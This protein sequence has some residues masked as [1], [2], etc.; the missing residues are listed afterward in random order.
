M[1]WPPYG[2]TRRYLAGAFRTVRRLAPSLVE[3]HNRPLLALRLV[4]AGTRTAL[5]LHNDP[6]GMEGARGPAERGALLKTMRIAC[7]SAFLRDRFMEGVEDFGAK[8]CVLPNGIDFAALPPPLP[9]AER[10][11]TLLFAGRTVADKGADVFVAACRLALP[12][13]PGWRALMIGADRYR[14]D[15]P[16]TPFLRTL[17]PHAAEAGVEMCG[18]HPHRAVLDA[19][20]RAAIVVVPSRWDEPFGLVALEAAACGAAVIASPRGAL[21]EILGD[22]AVYTAPDRPDALAE[23][24]VALAQSSEQ[25]AALGEAGRRRAR[26]FDAP[27]IRAQHAA[28]RAGT[29]R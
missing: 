18:Y 29:Q 28:W 26:A 2:Q 11:P 23:T 4:R 15:S 21:P 17:R 13:C 10:D 20:A 27:I 8:P 12:Q 1:W 9:A 6:H 14:S 24:I 5:V 3:V 22:A 7:V 25:R 16:D 19:M